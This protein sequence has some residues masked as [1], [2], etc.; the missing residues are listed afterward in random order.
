MKIIFSFLL[1]SFTLFSQNE[2]DIFIKDSVMDNLNNTSIS[3]TDYH[4]L[5]NRISKL[6]KAYGY[7]TD[8]HF[9]LLEHSFIQNDLNFFKEDLVFLIKNYGFN[10]NY[11]KG[12]ELYFDSILQ[13]NLSKWFKRFYVKNYSKWLKNNLSKS[14]DIQ[15]MHDMNVKDQVMVKF[16]REFDLNKD[17]DTIQKGLFLQH[18][19]NYSFRNIT[20]LHFIAKKYGFLPNSKNFALTY[21]YYESVLVHNVRDNT[22][23]TW[24]LLF[25]Y[26]KKAYLNNEIG[27]VVFQNY[28][29]YHYLRYG[30]QVFNSYT[31][32]QIPKSFRKEGTSIPLKDEAFYNAIK[33]EFKWK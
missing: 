29:F 4:V 8:F 7:E 24:D 3:N 9:K 10:I 16:S 21:F 15:K 30:T 33:K 6:D 31:L 20:D 5:K 28:D 18:L 32:D 19:Y 22:D 2:R 23:A 13:G 25:P 26:F 12:S 27:N 14:I 17:F 1:F 11:L